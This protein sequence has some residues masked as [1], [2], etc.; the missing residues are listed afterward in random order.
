MEKKDYG[1]F[2]SGC[3]TPEEMVIAAG[4]TPRRILPSPSETTVEA[5]KWIQATHCSIARSVLNNAITGKYRDYAG[6]LLTHGCDVTS[7]EFDVWKVHADVKH[8]HYL[9]VPLKVDAIAEKFYVRELNRFKSHL[10]ELTGHAI[11]DADIS[12]AIDTCNETRRLLRNLDALRAREPPGIK[13]SEL[14]QLV[15]EAQVGVKEEVNER[16]RSTLEE[17]KGNNMGAGGGSNGRPR[18]LLTGS[19]VDTKDLLEMIED[20]GFDIVGDDLDIGGDYYSFN[21]EKTGDPI[22]DIAHGYL[23]K[24]TN[25]TK[26]PPDQR[27]DHL[28]KLASD[29]KVDGVIYQTVKFCEPYLYDSVFITNHFKEE[30]KL[31]VLYFERE[32]TLQGLSQIRTR[33]EAF[34]EMM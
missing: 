1:W 4:L 29:R 28:V 5:D 31:P 11:D 22:R 2:D 24:P 7:R 18:V 13:A 21:I 16:L 9:N 30:E 14:F 19:I 23:S 32:Y 15:R 12:T 26:H 20:A 33:L 3:Y 27:L 25:S 17:I 8:L 34:R 10:E 6:V